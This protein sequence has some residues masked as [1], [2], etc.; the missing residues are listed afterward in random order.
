MQDWKAVMS[1][2]NK[3]FTFG[4]SLLP[5][6]KWHLVYFFVKKPVSWLALTVIF[7]FILTKEGN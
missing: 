6:S 3:H 5:I 4:T 1:H 7:L 2:A